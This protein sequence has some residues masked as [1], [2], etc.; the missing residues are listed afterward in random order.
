[1]K[2][3]KLI[4][5]RLPLRGWAAIDNIR[6][7][8]EDSVWSA[9][10][11]LVHQIIEL[12]TGHK[13]NND[14]WLDDMKLF[15][16]SLEMNMPTKKFPILETKEKS[17]PMPWEYPER[18]WY[19]WE[20]LFAS[21]YGWEEKVIAELDI[22]TCIG[23]YQEIIIDQQ[24]G[25]EWQASLSEVSYTY[26]KSSKTSRLQKLPRPNWMLR[27]AGEAKPIKTFMMP[28]IAAPMGVVINLDEKQ[29]PT[30]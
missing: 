21:H 11:S 13:P 27:T 25:Q 30:T 8:I 28:A 5:R 10:P 15:V 12:T 16:K 6:R 9:V 22:D 29:T 2:N 20:N 4:P 14:F 24:L 18:S 7:K 19:F 3:K 23:L 26:D 17:D 1:M